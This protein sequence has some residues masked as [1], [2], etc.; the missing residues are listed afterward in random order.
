MKNKFNHL[1]VIGNGFD[2]NH[3]YKTSYNDFRKY[4]ISRFQGADEYDGFIPESIPLPD[5]GEQYDEDEIAGYISR[6][7]DDCTGGDWCDLETYL[8]SPMIDR[9]TYDLDS[10]DPEDESEKAYRQTFNINEERSL[11]MMSTLPRVKKYFCD[12]IMEYYSGFTY[13]FSKLFSNVG[14]IDVKNDVAEVLKTGDCFLNFNY[15]LTLDT[16]I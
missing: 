4:L 13:G 2:L 9:L 1:F 7:L 11:N 14:S 15:T 16:I 8:G 12:W 3:N 6:I 5:G 10:F